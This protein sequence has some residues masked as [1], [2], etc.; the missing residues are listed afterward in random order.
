MMHYVYIIGLLAVNGCWLAGVLFLLPG[1]W[2]MAITT[3]LFAWWRWDEGV[4]GVGVLSAIATMA[5]AGEIFD[6]FAGAGG[7]KKAGASWLGAMAAIFGAI[8]GALLGTVLIPIPVV[9]TLLGACFGAGLA[10]WAAERIIGKSPDQSAK[11]GFGAG[12]GVLLGITVKFA[13]G[14]VIWLTVAV[15]AFW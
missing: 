12:T 13:I 10:V 8:A 5:L 3:A 6:F 9:G 1:N 2:L 14:C 7:A 15:A 11:S 4:F